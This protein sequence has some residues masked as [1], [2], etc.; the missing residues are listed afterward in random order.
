[1]KVKPLLKKLKVKSFLND[2]L[3][4]C[5]IENVDK[6]LNAGLNI[7]DNPWHYPNMAKGVKRLNKAIVGK[8]LIAV[9]VD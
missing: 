1:M 9:L 2:Y 6:Y 5:G 8:E 4:A 3:Q 7:V